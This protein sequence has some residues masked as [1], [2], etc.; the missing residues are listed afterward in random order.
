MPKT[1]EKCVPAPARHGRGSPLPNSFRALATGEKGLS[2]LSQMP[3]YY[4]NSIIH[5]SIG[6]FMIQGGGTLHISLASQA[7]INLTS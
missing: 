1:A 7:T 3:L 4:K 6:G 2:Q 5:R